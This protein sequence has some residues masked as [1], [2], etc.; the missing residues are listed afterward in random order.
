MAL[1]Q[2]TSGS[3]SSFWSGTLGYQE[4]RGLDNRSRFDLF[5]SRT[6]FALY[7]DGNKITE[8]DFTKPLPFTVA[9]VYFSH[10]HYHTALE[11]QELVVETPWEAYSLVSGKIMPRHLVCLL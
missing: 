5:V 6:H 9:K 1:T 8:H 10:Y 3:L 2:T 4:G 7:E 11:I